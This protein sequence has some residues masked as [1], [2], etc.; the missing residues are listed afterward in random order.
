MTKIKKNRQSKDF[1]EIWNVQTDM[2]VSDEKWDQ[3][4]H[5]WED[6]LNCKGRKRVPKCTICERLDAGETVIRKYNGKEY[7][8]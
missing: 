6:P 5:N 3:I 1:L 2:N 8:L 7:K 4:F